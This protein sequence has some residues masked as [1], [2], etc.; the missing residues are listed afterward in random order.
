MV[1]MQSRGTDSTAYSLDPNR[2][3]ASLSAHPNERAVVLGP[4]DS[5]SMFT[6]SDLSTELSSRLQ[7]PSPGLLKSHYPPR[8]T[9]THPSTTRAILSFAADR[10]FIISSLI[11]LFAFLLTS[12]LLFRYQIYSRSVNTC[13]VRDFCRQYLGSFTCR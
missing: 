3:P 6:D 1:E 13:W 7:L 4:K 10:L 12:F 2:L 11:C 9:S 8:N 5:V